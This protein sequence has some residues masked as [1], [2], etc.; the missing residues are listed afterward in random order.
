[1]ALSKLAFFKDDG[2]NSFVRSAPLHIVNL[3]LKAGVPVTYRTPVGAANLI[4][5]ATGE[6]WVN[7]NGPAQVPLEGTEHG[8][9]LN[10]LGYQVGAEVTI[11]I[12]A[13]NDTRMSIAVYS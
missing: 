7:P 11:G 8:S 9:E 3:V 13:L 12:V 5:S 2:T 6:Y 10:P 1:M 4:F